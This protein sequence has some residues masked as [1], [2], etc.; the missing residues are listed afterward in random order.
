MAYVIVSKRNLR[1]IIQ[2]V[3]IGDCLSFLHPRGIESID[4][5]YVYNKI[6]PIQLF[7]ALRALIASHLNILC[8]YI[9]YVIIH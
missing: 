1:L 2:H 9:S 5:M 4:G 3:S 8:Q 7:S 6:E